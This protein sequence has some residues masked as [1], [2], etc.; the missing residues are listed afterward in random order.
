MHLRPLA[1]LGP[2][3]ARPRTALGR[4]LQYPRT[5]DGSTQDGSTRLRL[6]AVEHA[7]EQAQVMDDSLKAA[8]LHPAP[9]LLVD[10]GPRREVARQVAPGR[11]G[12]GQVAQRVEDRAQIMLALQ[13]IKGQ[14]AQVGR[15]KRPFVVAHITGIGLV[16]GRDGRHS[17]MLSPSPAQVH[18][19]L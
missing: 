13:G 3:V 2:A 5:Q 1:P 7:H 14:Q 11:S 9:R 12:V 16:R 17:G 10:G 19:T 15:D 4:R 8:R 6:V 18:N